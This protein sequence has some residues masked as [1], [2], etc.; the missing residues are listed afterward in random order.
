MLKKTTLTGAYSGLQQCCYCSSNSSLSSRS[1]TPPHNLPAQRA[2]PHS[3]YA[4]KRRRTTETWSWATRRHYATVRHT[5]GVDFR[6]NMNWPCRNGQ[7]VNTTGINPFVPSPYEIF[8]M[9]RRDTYGRHTKLKYYELVK[10][11]HPDRS[12]TGCESLSNVERLERVSLIDLH[13]HN[14]L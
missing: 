2:R 7:S 3:E 1:S 12:G 9:E 5:G 6:D 14:V 13:Y 10:I 4:N 11:Y 8:D